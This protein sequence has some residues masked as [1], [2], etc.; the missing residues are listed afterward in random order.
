MASDVGVAPRGDRLGAVP[1]VVSAS[2]AQLGLLIDPLPGQ[3]GVGKPLMRVF[4][5]V[6]QVSGSHKMIAPAAQAGAG[7]TLDCFTRDALREGFQAEPE[8]RHGPTPAGAQGQ[9]HVG[10]NR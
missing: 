8:R 6:H 5:P 10:M 7:L 2:A 3:C 1:F 9:A 4:L